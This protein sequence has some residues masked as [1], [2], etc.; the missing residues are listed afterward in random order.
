MSLAV[1]TG[2]A[3][4]IG[5]HLAEALLALGRRVRIVDDLSTGSVSNVP[6]EAELLRANAAQ[7]SLEGAEVVFHLA[8]IPSVP[9]SIQHP[10][11]S[12]EA[13]A[14]TTLAVLRGAAR[15]GVRRVVYASSSSVYG[16]R[17]DLP[18][19]E[20]HVPR[21]MSPYAASKLAGEMYCAQAARHWGV[22]TVSLRFFN[23]YGPRQDPASPYAAVIPIFLSRLRRGDPLPVYGDGTQTRD[24][25][26]VGDVARGLLLASKA[27]RISGSVFN[28]AGGCP[29]SLLALAEALGRT[30]GVNPRLEFLPPR[31]GDIRESYADPTLARERLGFR[32][33]TSLE[34]GLSATARWFAS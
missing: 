16:E 19:R 14:A 3:G 6:K 18:K 29:V 25:T 17:P 24:F 1:V 13:N 21:P 11:E 10:I 30:L 20:D 26:Y 28:L 9:R 23:V 8:A 27:P 34:E 33:A 15:A 12:D 22:E 5:S 32:I 2:G 31:P 7:A 4:F